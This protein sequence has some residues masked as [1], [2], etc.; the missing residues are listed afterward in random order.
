MKLKG[1]DPLG[2]NFEV[3]SRT[4]SLGA[5]STESCDLISSTR[6]AF[7][8]QTALAATGACT[9]SIVPAAESP[10]AKHRTLSAPLACSDITIP[11]KDVEGK[12]AFITG[13]SSGIGLGIARAFAEAGM[14]VAIGYRGQNHLDEALAALAPFGDR[15][16][17]IRVDVT[18][19][20]GLEQAAAETAT[21]FGK[22]HVVVANAGVQNRASLCAMTYED[23]AQLMRVNV[24]GVFHTV[25]AFVPHI[26]AHG[27]GGQVVT[28]ASIL[29]LFTVGAEYAAYCSSKF[30]AV[31]MMETLRVELEDAHIGVSAVCPGV[32]KSNLEEGLKDIDFASDPLEVGRLVLRGIRNNDLYILTHPEFS[33]VIHERYE[34][35]SASSPNNLRPSEARLAAARST[36][37]ESVYVRE[38][39]RLQCGEATHKKRTA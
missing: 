3:P 33:R 11:L 29:G 6:R 34:V 1:I 32:V 19:R 39:M 22:V 24:D 21:H 4:S 35:L 8:T 25:Q 9:A 10:R 7:L 15:I 23:W 17:S 31:A 5:S 18:D 2:F 27:E 16:H 30:A 28:T 38:R 26:K 13:G 14:K 20:P 37:Q 36:E 12:V